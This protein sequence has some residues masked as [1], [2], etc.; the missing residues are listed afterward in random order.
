MT[1]DELLCDAK[2]LVGG[3]NRARERWRSTPHDDRMFAQ[4]H[5]FELDA[6]RLADELE[7]MIGALEGARQ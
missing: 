3:L 6:V 5:D 4:N 7:T 1:N 2:A